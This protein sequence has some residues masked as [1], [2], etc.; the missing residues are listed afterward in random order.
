MLSKSA[1]LTYRNQSPVLSPVFHCFV[2]RHILNPEP[3]TLV[4]LIGHLQM[5][6]LFQLVLNGFNV[7]QLWG[8]QI[9]S[10]YNRLPATQSV[11]KLFLRAG[12]FLAHCWHLLQTLQCPIQFAGI[13]S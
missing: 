3:F 9:H 1:F 7:L 8:G 5:I 4:S 13:T 2:S 11:N 6:L 10:L 12:H